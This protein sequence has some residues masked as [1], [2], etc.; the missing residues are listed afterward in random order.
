MNNLRWVL[1]VLV[2]SAAWCPVAPAQNQKSEKPTNSAAKQEEQAPIGQI[3]GYLGLGV[4][5]LHSSLVNHLSSLIGGEYGLLVEEVVEGSPAALAGVK[6][7]DVLYRYDDQ[8]LFAAEQLVRLVHGDKPGQEVALGII[9]GGKAQTV[10]VT[11]GEQQVLTAARPYR[12][13]RKPLAERLSRPLTVEEREAPWAL[14][15]SMTL[16]RVDE[17][18]FKAQIK[19]RDDHGKVETRNFEGTRDEIRRAIE[20]QKDLP[21]NERDHLLRA[22]DVPAGILEFDVSEERS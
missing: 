7:N 19:Y 8:K 18:H 5:P 13:F 17:N 3:N 1:P 12:A 22:M 6:P 9:R 16:T 4:E 2:L 21:A 14:F 10:K 20:G 15:D 11:L